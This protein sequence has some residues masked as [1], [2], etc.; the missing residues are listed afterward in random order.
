[1]PGTLSLEPA[2]LGT[3]VTVTQVIAAPMQRTVHGGWRLLR[4]WVGDRQEGEFDPRVTRAKGGGLGPPRVHPRRMV[5]FTA[6]RA[7]PQA[8]HG[9][10]EDEYRG[11][12][13]R[14]T[15]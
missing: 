10:R 13:G 4:P 3:S 7:W 9:C 1:M 11:R 14:V 8:G 6:R 2:W 15:S 5:T 12:R